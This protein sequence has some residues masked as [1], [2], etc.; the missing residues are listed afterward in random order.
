MANGAFLLVFATRRYLVVIRALQAHKFPIDIRGTL[1]A[2]VLTAA[3][4]M[5]SLSLMVSAEVMM[6][7]DNGKRERE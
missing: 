5:T 2:V 1:T 7:N 4:T 6:S 3:S